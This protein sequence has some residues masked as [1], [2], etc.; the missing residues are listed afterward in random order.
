M[1]YLVDA[2]V[3]CEPSKKRPEPKVISWLRAHDSEI[4]ISALSLGEVLKGIHLLDPGDRREEIERWYRRL[5]RWAS[6]R[7]L[8]LDASVFSEWAVLYARHQRGG[9]KLPL[10]DSFLAATALHHGLTVATRNSADF[11]P[12]VHV[13]NPWDEQTG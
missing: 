13:F 7:I 6:G 8:P 3:L 10:V 2:N 12:E 5:E 4:L 11:P 1:A 9:R